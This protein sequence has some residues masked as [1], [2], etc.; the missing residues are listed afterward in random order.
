VRYARWL[1]VVSVAL[2]AYWAVMAIVAIAQDWPGEFGTSPEDD[3]DTVW[4]WIWRG[5]LVHAPL[6]P[7]L[8]QLAL[9][10]AAL[11]RRRAWLVVAGIGLTLV[12][13]LYAIGYV[14]EPPLRP[15]RSDPPVA[16]YVLVRV[17]GLVGVLALISLGIATAVGALRS[18]RA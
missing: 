1:V 3:P 18:R 15:E 9:T 14:G 6:P 4:E 11:T 16:L 12:G 7:I 5:S 17:V 2:L 8:V 13:A 10:L